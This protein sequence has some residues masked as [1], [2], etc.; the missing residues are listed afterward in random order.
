M[1]NKR[2]YRPFS[3]SELIKFQKSLINIKNPL[4]PIFNRK[5]GLFPISLI[6]QD[7]GVAGTIY[8]TSKDEGITWVYDEA[9]DKL[10]NP[11]FTGDHKKNNFD[12]K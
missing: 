4:S 3:F 9:Y 12:L 7:T 5:E 8:L 10:L 11:F 6:D 1:L 2:F